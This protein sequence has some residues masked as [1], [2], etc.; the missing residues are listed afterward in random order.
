MTWTA[1][2]VKPE[3]VTAEFLYELSEKHRLIPENLTA[4]I[5]Y[6]QAI[7]HS[8]A[9]IQVIDGDDSEIVADV[10]ISD[11]ADGDSAQIDMVPRPKYFAP[12]LPDGSRNPDPYQ[13]KI[14][15]ALAPVFTKLIT[16]R[17]LRRLTAMV[18]K[19]RS[20]TFKALKACGFKKEGVMRQA[21]KFK[22]RTEAE[23]LVIMGMLPE[24]E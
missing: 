21:V 24:K 5:E 19:S 4:A 12:I 13:Q 18:P 2:A 7:C 11:I 1:V 20:R 8:C 9:V 3:D 17:N 6:Y 16:G 14:E 10:I 22:G 23:D 15:D